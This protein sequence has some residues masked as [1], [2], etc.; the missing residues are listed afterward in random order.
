VFLEEIADMRTFAV[1]GYKHL[2]SACLL[3][4]KPSSPSVMKCLDILN[5][6]CG[7]DDYIS[8]F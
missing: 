8:D 6:L 1:L 3:L 5:A 2:T 4:F 7:K